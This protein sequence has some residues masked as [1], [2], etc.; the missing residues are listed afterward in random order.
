MESSNKQQL[1]C[2]TER[3]RGSPGEGRAEERKR[4]SRRAGAQSACAPDASRLRAGVLRCVRSSHITW[5]GP[6]DQSSRT[7]RT[8]WGSRGWGGGD[9]SS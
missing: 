6:H 1:G 5:Q 9:A 3:T 8:S 7:S 4:G 2:R